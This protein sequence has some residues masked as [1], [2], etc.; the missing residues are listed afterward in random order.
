MITIFFSC[1]KEDENLMFTIKGTVKFENGVVA[2]N[3]QVFLDDEF[4]TT[5]DIEGKFIINNLSSGS[6]ELK[7]RNEAT[8]S[9]FTEIEESIN[10]G[11]GD[12]EELMLLPLPVELHAPSLVTST[13]IDL[14]WS[15]Y[16]GSGFREY[17]I[18]IHDK[19]A[20]NEETGTLL[21]ISTDAN[22]T[23][24]SVN[25]GDFWWAGY[26]LSP[27]QTYFFRVFVMN[28]YG[29]E[30]GSNILQVKTALW[31]NENEFTSNYNLELENSFAAQG[32]LT[33]IAWDGNYYWMLYVESVGGYYD[34]NIVTIAK[35]DFA[36]GIT[37]DTI[38]F[39]D[40]NLYP[41]GMTW[42]GSNIW[43]A[44]ADH[45]KSVDIE[46]EVFDKTYFIGEGAA[47]LA[48]NNGHIAILDN[49][50]VVNVLN[51]INGSIITNFTT[52]FVNI[53][54]SGEM[55][56]AYRDNEMWIINNWHHQIC[57]VDDKGKHIGI[58]E[59]D[60]LQSGFNSNNHKAPMCFVNDKLVIALDS[61]VRTYTITP[62]E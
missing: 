42:D 23:T 41:M 55:G 56:I 45:I 50:N 22:D 10:I 29:I 21:H 54:Y 57:I 28:E 53:G 40:S 14:N 7:V 62:T 27:D 17:H 39:N 4:T 34:N 24:L 43:I 20:L 48:F 30:S 2:D 5:T 38:I 35:Y 58:A 31:D 1:Q 37:L 13:S 59:V 16:S 32:N 18:Y 51:P 3:S 19:S 60:F 44:Y 6:Y 46:K 12:I 36:E 26:T 52:P 49:W 25:A 33:G 47:D 11:K 61:Q 8:T 9:G 15:R